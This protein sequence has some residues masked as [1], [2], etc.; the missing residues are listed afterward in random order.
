MFNPTSLDEVCVQ[1]T[2]LESRG[3]NVTHDFIKPSKS[4]EKNLKAKERKRKR[5]NNYYEEG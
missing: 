2:H 5:K 1:A 4:T 3:K